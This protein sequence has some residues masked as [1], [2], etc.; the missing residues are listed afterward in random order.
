MQS[1]ANLVDSII[2]LTEE[3]NQVIINSDYKRYTEL[4]SPDLSCFEPEGDGHLIAGLKFHEFYFEQWDSL[5]E[6]SKIK[7]NLSILSPHV[8]ILA[9]NRVAVIGYI[10]MVQFFDGNNCSFKSMSWEETRVW[11]LEEKT[12]KWMQVHFH[13]SPCKK[14]DSSLKL[15]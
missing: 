12:G 10:K 15:K 3:L 14:M 2:K 11:N 8:N 6:N 7:T 1:S 5:K 13:R 4:T 9:D